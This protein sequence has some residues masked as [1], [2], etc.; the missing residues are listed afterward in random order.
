M[1]RVFLHSFPS[2]ILGSGIDYTCAPIT[3]ANSADQNQNA[4]SDQDL[5]G[6]LT[7]CSIENLI[8]M[9]NITQ[10]PFKGKLAGPTDK[11]GK[12]FSA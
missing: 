1:L 10:Q 4:E 11:R 12:F 5:H 6:L 2:G 3:K 9:K 7:E 8:K